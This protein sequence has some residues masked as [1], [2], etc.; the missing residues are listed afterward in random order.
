[1]VNLD[2]V[3]RHDNI[4]S[5]I[6]SNTPRCITITANNAITKINTSTTYNDVKRVLDSIYSGDPLDV[7]CDSNKDENFKDV[8]D[9][10]LKLDKGITRKE[11]DGGY[12]YKSKALSLATKLESRIKYI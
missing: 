9:Y 3:K 6:I 2:Y 12:T 10:L 1:M 11:C 8:I 5:I 4:L 7:V